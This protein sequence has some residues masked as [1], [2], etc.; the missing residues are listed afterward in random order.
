MKPNLRR[1]GLCRTLAHEQS[2]Q[3]LFRVIDSFLRKCIDDF[4]KVSSENG[5]IHGGVPIRF[6]CE[7]SP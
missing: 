1:G 3:A 6:C 4:T 5:Q 2:I 7:F